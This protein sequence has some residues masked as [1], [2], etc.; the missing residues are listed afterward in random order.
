MFSW[1]IHLPM[2][3]YIHLISSPKDIDHVLYTMLIDLIPI[4]T[5]LPFIS[6]ALGIKF[7]KVLPCIGVWNCPTLPVALL[8]VSKLLILRSGLLVPFEL[9]S[10]EWEWD[11]IPR[12]HLFYMGIHPVSPAKSSRQYSSSD[13]FWLSLT[14]ASCL[15]APKLSFWD[16]WLAAWSVH[17]LLSKDYAGL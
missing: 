3:T 6:Y 16:F 10:V 2:R 5:I 14:R 12:F 11:I 7:T 4:V 1:P 17:L 15:Q 8:I 13:I 9:N